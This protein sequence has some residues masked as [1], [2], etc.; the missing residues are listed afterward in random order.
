MDDFGF[1]VGDSQQPPR[2]GFWTELCNS[3]QTRLLEEPGV[4]S[5]TVLA[6][7]GS[8]IRSQVVA[9][10]VAPHTLVGELV[11]SCVLEPVCTIGGGIGGRGVGGEDNGVHGIYSAFASTC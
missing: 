10:V 3:D 1:R 9:A 7:R 8:K 4:S 6:P 2:T 11:F 5:R